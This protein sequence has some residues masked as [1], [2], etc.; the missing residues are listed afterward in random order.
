MGYLRGVYHLL[1]ALLAH[2]MSNKENQYRLAL[3]QLLAAEDKRL[4]LVENSIEV[5]SI[6]VAKR[7]KRR[8]IAPELSNYALA[9][10]T[11]VQRLRK[12]LAPKK[13]TP[14][15]EFLESNYALYFTCP[16]E[17]FRIKRD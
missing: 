9:R 11:A 7:M 5:M 16:R 8:R 17:Q 3:E 2:D 1:R 10:L 15:R 6:K 4:S 14:S 12:S 13:F